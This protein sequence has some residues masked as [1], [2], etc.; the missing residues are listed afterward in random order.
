M[1]GCNK[2]N[3][4]NT[5]LL[6]PS[7]AVGKLTGG[8]LSALVQG[9]N[10]VILAVNAAEGTAAEKNCTGAVCA[11]DAGLF[12]KMGRNPRYYGSCTHTA[13]AAAA[14]FT[15]LCVAFSRT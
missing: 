1:V 5:L 8:K 7:V 2:V 15:S 12:A 11:A 3:V 6:K 14:F 13:K 9:G 10:R 4:V